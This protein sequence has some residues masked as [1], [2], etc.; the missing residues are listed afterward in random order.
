M[1]LALFQPD[2]PQNLGAAIRLGACLDTPVHVIEPCG[3]PL[4]DKAIRRAALDYGDPAEV[5]RHPDWNA[6][7]AAA[8]GRIVLFTTRGA[9]PLHD[10]AFRPDDILLFGRESAGVPDFVHESADA[11]VIIP[12]SRGRRS[13]NLTVS[14]AIGLSEALRQTGRFPEFHPQ[15]YPSHD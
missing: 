5:V 12:L 15:D 8:T 13:F 4:S 7:Q 2:I 11:R 10:F 1:L 14:A 9:V 3:F 6:F